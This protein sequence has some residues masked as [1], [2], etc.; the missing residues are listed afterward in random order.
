MN[1]DGFGLFKD[2]VISVVKKSGLVY[3]Y[4]IHLG[5]QKNS[6]S[7]ELS[8]SNQE[9]L[10]KYFCDASEFLL[11]EVQNDNSE[12]IRKF[13]EN[14]LIAFVLYTNWNVNKALEVG[15]RKEHD[16][17][18]YMFL[19]ES[20]EGVTSLNQPGGNFL[21]WVNE[22]NLSQLKEKIRLT[23]E[24]VTQQMGMTDEIQEKLL[25]A[26][27][28][29]LNGVGL[30]FNK[31]HILNVMYGVFL[32]TY[33]WNFEISDNKITNLEKLN[34]LF[35]TSRLAIVNDDTVENVLRDYISFVVLQ[36]K[37]D[38]KNHRL[39]GTE[40]IDL[41]FDDMY[42]I[43]WQSG[44]APLVLNVEY[45]SFNHHLIHLL[46][47]VNSSIK[48]TFLVK[49]EWIEDLAQ[50]PELCTQLKDL[51]EDVEIETVS[52]VITLQGRPITLS[53]IC[54]VD[55]IGFIDIKDIIYILLQQYNIDH[56]PQS[57][58]SNYIE[59]PFNTIWIDPHALK[60]LVSDYFIIKST[61]GIDDI[62]HFLLT[63]QID[64][65]YDAFSLWNHKTNNNELSK[66]NV[67]E[68]S[69]NAVTVKKL[70]PH[71]PLHFL[72][73]H[74]GAGFEWI[75]SYQTNKNM[76]K[77]ATKSGY[78]FYQKQMMVK[79]LFKLL[80][81]EIKI[82]NGVSGS[83]K[84]IL[85]DYIANTISTKWWVVRINLKNYSPQKLCPT[86]NP[87][88]KIVSHEKNTL[89]EILFN[90][91]QQKGKIIIL[92][93]GFDELERDHF[94]QVIEMIRTFSKLNYVTYITTRPNYKVFLETSLHTFSFSLR[95]LTDQEQRLYLSLRLTTT[96]SPYS[97]ERIN[98][99]L[100]TEEKYSIRP[101]LHLKMLTDFFCLSDNIQNV[102]DANKVD[103]LFLCKYFVDL[104]KLTINSELGDIQT[105]YEHYRYLNACKEIFNYSVT[106]LL[107]LSERID[108]KHA[109]FPNISNILKEDK[110]L[111]L[112]DDSNVTFVHRMYSEYIIARWLSEH[113]SKVKII[114]KLF[115]TKYVTIRKM[116]DEILASECPLHLAV[117]N[118]QYS[119][120]KE[121]IFE[122]SEAVDK[123]DGGG[124]S[125]L[126]LIGYWDNKFEKIDYCPIEEVSRKCA[127]TNILKAIPM[128]PNSKCDHLLNYSEV[129]YAMANESS[130]VA[131]ELCL[132][133]QKISVKQEFQW[134]FEWHESRL[135]NDLMLIESIRFANS[136][137]KPSMPLAW[138]GNIF[139]QNYLRK[140]ILYG[141]EKIIT[142]AENLFE[143]SATMAKCK[144]V[145]IQ[146]RTLLHYAACKGLVGISRILSQKGAHIL[147]DSNGWT[148]LHFASYYGH[149][150]VIKLLLFSTKENIN[151]ADKKQRT[152]LL[153]AAEK[154]YTQVVQLLLENGADVNAENNCN[155]TALCYAVMQ[156]DEK[157]VK[158]LLDYGAHTEY[159]TSSG[160]TP[161]LL[162]SSIGCLEI[163][164]LL[165]NYKCDLSV[166]DNQ[167][168]TA[169]FLASEAGHIEIVKYLS[170][171]CDNLEVKNICGSSPLNAAT[172]KGHTVVVKM[173]LDN[174]ANVNVTDNANW[175]PL[176]SAVNIGNINITSVLLQHDANIEHCTLS[177]L[178]PLGCAARENN[179]E[180][181]QL[182]L[183]KGALI[184]GTSLLDKRTALLYAVDTGHM[185]MVKILLNNNANIH[186]ADDIR[187]PLLKAIRLG[188]KEILK[189]LLGKSDLSSVTY[190]YKY[191]LLCEAG[192]T[193]NVE[194]AKMLLNMGV[195]LEARDCISPLLYAASYGQTAVLKMFLKRGASLDATDKLGRTSLYLAASNGYLLTVRVLLN[196]GAA[197]NHSNKNGTALFTAVQNEHIS[198][199]KL[200]LQK[201]A[202]VSNTDYLNRTALSFAACGNNIE[203]LTLLLDYHSNIEHQSKYGLTP[204]LHAAKKGQTAVI[205]ILLDR[206]AFINAK[207]QK[208]RTAVCHA[209]YEGHTGTVKLLV[210]NNC[211]LDERCSNGFNILDVANYKRHT[212]I[213]NFLKAAKARNNHGEVSSWRVK[214]SDDHKRH[215]V[216]SN[217]REKRTNNSNFRKPSTASNWRIRDSSD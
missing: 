153:L 151:Y 118:Q 34:C 104:Y 171:K 39:N 205:K 142:M 81:S 160:V 156:S 45:L 198:T 182:L 164:K 78:V 48:V 29:R 73:F 25:L 113:L 105:H 121:I 28:N 204:L 200:L 212:D 56:M 162:A 40:V 125:I 179:M 13:K 106:D 59:T 132:K 128:I 178:T 159:H 120:A 53:E 8:T 181:A 51:D 4:A 127:I 191:N 145:D 122:D 89:T 197:I 38:M 158:M 123:L 15:E 139:L 16:D 185:E 43:M 103:L 31:E 74:L 194:V 61:G 112:S 95:S 115:N 109:E 77:Y 102:K 136:H 64:I 10:D 92:M 187:T 69:S 49:Q 129:D 150:E 163:V 208:N 22:Y 87:L 119:L 169:L 47:K 11:N 33:V 7:V 23:I 193:N 14:R 165:V 70:L 168:C 44:K 157:G 152:P 206:G 143:N 52:S 135:T 75:H 149:Q 114:E 27:K 211:D 9:L 138:I 215:G 76:V 57:I 41:T 155:L 84:S 177:G 79:Q 67:I 189:L 172:I 80:G 82:I 30:P 68:R 72:N 196:H 190:D 210:S 174:G 96:S 110:V 183:N 66:I 161:L 186:L 18:C 101:P 21:L 60:D 97:A 71:K 203:I 62:R 32:Q 213:Y 166:K 201:G 192:K 36:F 94:E 133:I 26:V 54:E 55:S 214:A 175:T 91:F 147:T 63:F 209:T 46:H 17:D 126:H 20:I 90:Y 93:D 130:Y 141:D 184:N 137:A 83:G 107:R 50:Y 108:R 42:E 117:I 2:V 140:I 202:D 58:I 216:I 12:L 124:R 188:N 134:P 1:V 6:E 207:D 180:V 99:L 154:G 148:P 131:N 146:G 3:N 167:Q 86:D 195:G 199:V 85:I 98:L 173:L 65:D 19:R 88:K 116:F 5:R 37:N 111:Q 35:K 144:T 100:K 176:M 24:S 217:W 170:D